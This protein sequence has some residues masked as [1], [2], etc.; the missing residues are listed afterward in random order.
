MLGFFS[1][2]LMLKREIP[3]SYSDSILLLLNLSSPI[4]VSIFRGNKESFGNL[5]WD[6]VTMTQWTHMSAE[7]PFQCAATV[8]VTSNE[9][10]AILPPYRHCTNPGIF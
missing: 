2:T 8:R 7:L 4:Q 3:G 6:L 5:H 9:E 10:N 1:L